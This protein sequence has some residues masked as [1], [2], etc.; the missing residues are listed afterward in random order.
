M[1][2]ITLVLLLGAAVPGVEA[3]SREA[4]PADGSTA[5]PAEADALLL[6]A[7]LL[8][9][10]GADGPARAP[11]AAG[12]GALGD[13]RAVGPLVQASTD[14]SL[15]VR[16]AALRALARYPTPEAQR[17][18][19]RAATESD[20]PQLSKLA[21]ESL[22]EQGPSGGAVLLQLA[23]DESASEEVRS[24]AL[25]RTRERFPELL[26]AAPPPSDSS[27]RGLAIV[28][29]ALFGSYTLAAIGNLGA[30]QGGPAIGAA[31]GV[32]VGGGAALLLTQKVPLSRA[33]AGTIA[34]AGG[35]GLATGLVVGALTDPHP[36]SATVTSLGL[37]GELA[38]LV[39]ALVL[40]DR[41]SLSGG[42]VFFA[43]IAGLTAVSIAAGSLLYLPPRDDV[44][45]GLALTMGA[46]L[47]GLGLG[48][49][50]ARHLHF[51]TD[52]QFAV[53][54]GALLGGFL[55]NDLTLALT[56][57]GSPSRVRRQGG[58]WLLGPGLGAIAAGAFS[59]FPPGLTVNDELGIA[60]GAMLTRF[61]FGG[62]T[63]LLTGTETSDE[64]ASAAALVVGGL[65]SGRLLP[66][67]RLDGSRL[68]LGSIGASWGLWQGLGFAAWHDQRHPQATLSSADTGAVARLGFGLGGLLGIALVPATQV[69]AGQGAAA[70]TTGAWAL[71]LAH[72]ASVAGDSST[73]TLLLADLIASDA[74]LAAGALAVSPL[75][76][77][78]PAA[79]GVASLYGA[80]GSA[81]FSLGAALFT[82]DRSGAHPIAVANVFGT[83]IGLGVGAVGAATWHRALITA[84]A[85]LPAPEV[86]LAG[87]PLPQIAPLFARNGAGLSLIWR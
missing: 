80:T 72:W 59:Q 41:I 87:L 78:P 45:P 77:V 9:Y 26:A 75:F 31:G 30:N 66:H 42:D 79:I 40:R 11:G 7:L 64:G 16:T 51:D 27:G 47:V 34:S 82:G 8:L 33:Q 18:L 28:A 36:S 61:A 6:R 5:A 54:I 15:S 60:A 22:A 25:T 83:L 53:P 71:W 56:S 32:L 35:W 74:G 62:A 38:G 46:G 19:R 13:A 2:W 17:A 1:H 85:D 68:L 48:A 73:S 58:A 49:G 21:V 44:R 43:N 4:G 37:V 12:L 63:R 23:G 57:P 3:P 65:V 24:L 39:P 70:F 81:L 52:A 55:A 69:G 67:T 20:E 50:Y 86:R 10:S 14:R 84:A 29:G 76:R